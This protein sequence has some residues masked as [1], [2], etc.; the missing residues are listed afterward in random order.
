MRRYSEAYAN[1]AVTYKQL[2]LTYAVLDVFLVDS[3]GT[4]LQLY[5]QQVVA[6][7][8]TLTCRVNAS[9]QSK[10]DICNS[11]AQHQL[12]VSSTSALRYRDLL[13]SHIW[14]YLCRCCSHSRAG[15]VLA[16]PPVDS[17]SNPPAAALPAGH[18]LGHEPGLQGCPDPAAH[19]LGLSAWAD[20][21]LP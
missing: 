16:V 19:H 6:L 3:P 17:A 14:D 21:P 4:L 10:E 9:G 13:Q 20:L 15:A 2:T 1:A 18:R 11:S 12:N 5:F 8:S 7:S